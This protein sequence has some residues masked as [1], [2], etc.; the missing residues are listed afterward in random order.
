MRAADADVHHI[1]YGLV[2]ITGVSTGAD[3]LNQFVQLAFRGLYLCPQR[4]WRLGGAIS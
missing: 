1:A 4:C 3:V 2:G